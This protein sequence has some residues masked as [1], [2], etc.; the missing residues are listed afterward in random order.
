MIRGEHGSWLS[1]AHVQI[2][3][4]EVAGAI[5]F[6]PVVNDECAIPQHDQPVRPELLDGVSVP[7]LWSTSSRTKLWASKISLGN[8]ND[9]M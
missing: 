9:M 6:F 5:Q 8:W 3:S 2:T 7:T 4:I 1:A